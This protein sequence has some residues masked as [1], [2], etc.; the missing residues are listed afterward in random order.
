MCKYSHLSI[1]SILKIAYPPLSQALDASQCSQP[2]LYSEMRLNMCYPV[3]RKRGHQQRPPRAEASTPNHRPWLPAS[4]ATQNA[5]GMYQNSNPRVSSSKPTPGMLIRI[6]SDQ[7]RDQLRELRNRG[8]EQATKD[9]L[10][11][12]PPRIGWNVPFNNPIAL[13]IVHRRVLWVIRLL[14]YHSQA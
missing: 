4:P 13:R 9:S 11:A 3:K 5:D 6:H 10:M 12:E 8:T 2:L 14:R 7:S 1:H